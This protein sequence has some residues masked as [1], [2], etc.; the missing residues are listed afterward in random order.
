[1]F[2]ARGRRVRAKPYPARGPTPERDPMSSTVPIDEPHPSQLYVDAARLRGVLEWFDFDAPEYEPIP[3]LD[4]DAELVLSDGHTRAVAAYLSGADTL[5][6]VPDSDRETLDL[7]LYRDCVTWCREASV[8][9][10]ADLVGRV[11]SRETFLE[12][13]VARC[14]AAAD[15]GD[16]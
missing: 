5:E 10:V 2:A 7:D 4:L 12:D 11:V 8:T 13:W 3:V 14:Q 16:P 15:D 9:R 1:M 6:V